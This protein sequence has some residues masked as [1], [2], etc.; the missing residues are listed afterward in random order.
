MKIR[1][2]KITTFEDLKRMA[3][4]HKEMIET[5]KKENDSLKNELSSIKALL[6]K[7]KK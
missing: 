2:Q 4:E 1:V 3:F 7:Q 6:E 5:L